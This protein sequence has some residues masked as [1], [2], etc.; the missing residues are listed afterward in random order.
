MSEVSRVVWVQV[1]NRFADVRQP[2]HDGL[3]LSYLDDAQAF[4]GVAR[5]DD[6]TVTWQHD[7]DTKPRG[8]AHQD[9][10]AIE[11]DGEI[12]IERG[13]DYEERWCREGQLG[14]AAVL[15]QRAADGKIVSRVVSIGEVS[16]TVWAGIQPGGAE[17]RLTERGWEVET[18]A[19]SGA[20]PWSAV[21]ASRSGHVPGGWERVALYVNEEGLEHTS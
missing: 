12:L 15:E 21:L 9:S 8:P 14:P 18:L 5:L 10:A 17:L 20:I 7:L 1:G 13:T 4:S 3:H 19:G 16:V 6:A 2:L 11:R